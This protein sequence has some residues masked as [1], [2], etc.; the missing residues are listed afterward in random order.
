MQDAYRE[1]EYSFFDQEQKVKAI[2]V[3]KREFCRLQTKLFKRAAGP[4]KGKFT[5]NSDI[6]QFVR[7]MRVVDS[8]LH[9]SMRQCFI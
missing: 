5:I 6:R 2:T 8:G 4:H 1:V 7:D 3:T 9:L